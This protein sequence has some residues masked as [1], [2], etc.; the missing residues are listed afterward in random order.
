MRNAQNCSITANNKLHHNVDSNRG[1]E[2]ILDRKFSLP[3]RIKTAQCRRRGRKGNQRGNMTDTG[4]TLK[5][6]KTRKKTA[7]RKRK[8]EKTA[9]QKQ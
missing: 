9:L 6:E 7:G 5:G 2:K 4:T 1:P 8:K 3:V